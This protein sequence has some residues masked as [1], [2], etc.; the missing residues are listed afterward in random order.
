M[1]GDTENQQSAQH[2]GGAAATGQDVDFDAEHAPA[3]SRRASTAVLRH[4]AAQLRT[5][6]AAAVANAT[7]EQRDKQHA[8]ADLAELHAYQSAIMLVAKHLDEDA[9]FIYRTAGQT[10]GDAGA[11]PLLKEIDARVAKATSEVRHL[12][13]RIGRVTLKE[14]GMTED[15]DFLFHELG[16]LKHGVFRI[17]TELENARR[18][19]KSVGQSLQADTFSLHDAFGL[20]HRAL[21]KDAK[22][23]AP[24]P[25]TDIDKRP[26]AELFAETLGWNL[27]AVY[28][29]AR[30]VRMGLGAGQ[31]SIISGDLQK[32]GRHIGEVADL[33]ARITDAKSLKPHK[34]RARRGP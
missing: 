8:K 17:D 2:G 28:D 25:N 24:L 27:T 15:A 9:A 26:E 5:A 33:V 16:A 6:D 23:L 3:T 21:S 7:P 22:E 20:I 34:Q 29:A 13:M 19:A 4:K 12:S 31:D 10:A 11:D 1:S 32:M 14:S 18:F 30:S